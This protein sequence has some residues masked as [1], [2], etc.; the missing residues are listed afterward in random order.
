PAPAVCGDGVVAE[1][2]ICDDG[3]DDPDDGCNKACEQTGAV[4]W[5]YTHNGAA[6]KYDSALGVAI[7][8]T[9][10][11][12]IVGYESN[13][14]NK[15]DM[16]LI[17]LG[18]DGKELWKKTIEGAAALHE[19]FSSVVLDDAGNIYASGYEEIDK[20]ISDAVV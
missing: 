9:G 19:R 16:L 13:A 8:A 6:S 15:S 11:I 10:K 5:T 12:I 4:E 7:D 3:N 2:E 20:D 17:A 14:M 18:P 1:T